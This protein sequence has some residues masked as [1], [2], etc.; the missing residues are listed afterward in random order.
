MN[1]IEESLIKFGEKLVE[2]MKEILVTKDKVAT[3]E[4]LDSLE[5]FL[6]YE[7]Y[8]YRLD[9]SMADHAEYVDGM[10]YAYSRRPGR[11]MP[12]RSVI[13]QWMSVRGINGKDEKDTESIAYLIQRKIGIRGIK[14]TPFLHLFNDRANELYA[15]IEN[16][17]WQHMQETLDNYINE[18]NKK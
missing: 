5:P 12:P 6:V 14:A 4:L 18:L 8:K 11:K 10:G 17:S 9:I 13:K 15:V 1:P 3:G 16:A 2:D 7:K